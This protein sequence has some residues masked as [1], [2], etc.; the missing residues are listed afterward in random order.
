MNLNKVTNG[1][2]TIQEKRNRSN[3]CRQKEVFVTK[4]FLLQTHSGLNPT[5]KE[6]YIKRKNFSLCNGRLTELTC[7]R[8]Y[9]FFGTGKK[10]TGFQN[11]KW[12]DRL[13]VFNLTLVS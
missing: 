7:V 4:K 10:G 5:V 8:A 9:I 13:R 6:N 11:I 12:C 1:H 3:Y 2:K